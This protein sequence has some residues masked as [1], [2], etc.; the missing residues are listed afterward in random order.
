MY[1]QL[2]HYEAFALLRTGVS[3]GLW[4]PFILVASP[5]HSA[6]GTV[7]LLLGYRKNMNHLEHVWTGACVEKECERACAEQGYIRS[8]A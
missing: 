6:T 1:L 7:N 8:R 2:K 3:D 5:Q 4:L